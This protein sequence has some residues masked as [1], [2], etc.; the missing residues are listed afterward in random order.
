MLI[1]QKSAIVACFSEQ[2]LQGGKHYF[3]LNVPND[4]VQENI[5]LG[6]CSF[7][8]DSQGKAQME[9]FF[10]AKGLDRD[11]N[12]LEARRVNG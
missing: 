1:P 2:A 7:A 3:E 12:M 5:V 4:D 9:Q 8:P 11:G 6:L 10:G